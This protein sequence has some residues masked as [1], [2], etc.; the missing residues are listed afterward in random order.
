MVVARKEGQTAIELF[1][2]II[3]F[4]GGPGG[5][6]FD[7]TLAMQIAGWTIS[8]IGLGLSTYESI[9]GAKEKSGVVS[10]EQSE[11]AAIASQISKADPQHRSAST[12]EAL[13]SQQFGAGG[14]T[15]AVRCPEGFYATPDG[16]C[17]PIPAKAGIGGLP[18]WAWI[19]I[20]GLAFVAVKSGK[21]F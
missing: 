4:A 12:W 8:G 2:P 19:V 15:P 9:R 1:D 6:G 5:L 11:V 7:W 17:L 10:L 20:G 21:I 14:P 13:L 16:A 18:T 3:G